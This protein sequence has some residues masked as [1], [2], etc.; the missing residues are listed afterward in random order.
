VTSRTLLLLAAVVGST[1]V[2]FA[3][4]DAPSAQQAVIAKYCIT[5]HSSKLRTGGLSLQDVDLNNV[6]AAAE[7]W[8]KVIRKLRT[9][10]M[11]P[12][13]MPRPDTASVQNL[14][15]FLE[16]SLDRAA[17]AKPN[18]GHAA[19][20]RL[21]RS[22]YANAIHDLLALDVDATALLPPD[23]ESSGFDN[24]ADVLR[25]SPSLM[26][27]YLSASWNISRQ[28]VGNMNIAAE[29]ATYRVR[30]DLSQDQHIEGLPLG[31]RGGI[32][33]RHY[34][35]LDAEYLI[36]LRLWRNTFDLMRG[37]EDAH[38]IEISVDGKQVRLVTAGGHD[39]FLRMT[40]N[41]GTFGAELDKQLTVRLPLKA[42]AHVI[43]ASTILRSHAEKDDLIKP[44]LRTTVDGLDIMGDP[45]V[46]RLTV[47]GPLDPTGP[48][49]T[50][51]RAK[52]FVCT[53]QSDKDDLP[54]A[55]K[56]IAAL[57]RRAYRRPIQDGDLET[58]LSFYQRRRNGKGSFDAGIESSLQLIL[59]SPEFLFRFEPDPSGLPVDAAYQLSDLALASRLSFFLWS[60]PPDEELLKVASE[61]KLHQHAV[62]Q[63]Q[64]TRMLADD[65]ADALVDNFAEQWL[66]LRN[67]KNSSPDPQIF[68]DFDDN[69]RQA[70]REET[71]LFFRSMVRE[72]R[73][74]MDLLNADYTFVNE[75]LARHYGIPN[76]YG[77]QFRRVTLASD[78]RRG[79]LGQGSILTVTSYPNR[80]SPV[81]RGKWIL[82]NL[83][84]IPPTP[85]PPNV[86]ALKENGDG[87]PL[88]LRER[89]EQHR[90]DAVCSGCHKVMD[91]IGFALEN[92]DGVGQWRIQDDGSP[93]DPSGTLYNGA[94]VDGPVALRNMLADH[95]DVF[96]G[97]MT[98]KLLTY[99][100][101][102]GVEYY[103][104]PAVR[105]IVQQAQSNNLRFSSLVLGTVESV[106]FEMKIKTAGAATD[107][108]H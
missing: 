29:T 3:Q 84:G 108:S 78:A 72:D 51:S 44:F 61:G 95:P 74:V 64:V 16:I 6:P 32:L 80:T 73:S 90:A 34:A 19:M 93:I 8:E 4:P 21:N 37:M 94:K 57:L 52:I 65:R 103:D 85:P 59:S 50:P 11:P 30:P 38:Q 40:A 46:D 79:L 77:S 35:P 86:P 53:P 43:T 99:A 68:P 55:R 70:M 100:L 102:R 106:P 49:Q 66:F 23:D 41:P 60:S 33:V 54:C 76:V 83:L 2:A 10:S 15:S 14:A 104:M 1:V 45:S 56:I 105:K 91:P 87:K 22:E 97:V 13:G 36:K 25:M 31:T 107:A 39:E 63:Q 89:M 92:F 7:T 69:L 47:Q 96:A 27:R 26:E 88:S 18:P 98:E 28:A 42:G 101:G 81:Q 62:L 17:T 75:R 67:L 71:K 24:I 9:G 82:T 20:H 12:Q 48:G 58:P 5:C